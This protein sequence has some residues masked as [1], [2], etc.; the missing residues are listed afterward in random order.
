MIEDFNPNRSP[1]RPLES[2]EDPLA[3]ALNEL[4]AG[5]SIGRAGAS[6][7]RETSPFAGSACPEPGEWSRLA[8]GAAGSAEIDVLLAHAGLCPGCAG[9]LRRSLEM[10]SEDPLPEE[11]AEI[12]NLASGAVEWQHRLAIE[13]ARS[14]HR[15]FP[16]KWLKYKYLWA[17]VGLAACLVIA[18]SVALWRQHGNTPER[19]LAESYTHTRSFDLRMPGA[20]FSAVVPETHLRGGSTGRESAKLL[21]ARAGIERE[22]ERTPD[23][24]HWLQLEARADVM[25]E[26]FD[27]AID[28]LDRLLAAG[29]VTPGL[30]A[31]DASAYF[32]RGTASGSENDRATALD[33]LRRADE[34]APGDPVVLFN[35]AIAMED[36]GL[37]MNA[38]ET[39]NRYLRFERDPRWQAEGRRRLQE[40]ELKLNRIKSHE[41]RMERHLANPQAMRSLADDQA[42]LSAL[43]EELSSTR[44]PTLLRSAF[45]L[46]VDRSRGSPCD[47]GCQAARS[48]LQALGSSL[49]RN[50][51]DPW[52]TQF[53]SP[54][55][56]FQ[57]PQF[58]QAALF[59]GQAIDAD[60]LGDYSGGQRWSARARALFHDLGN[61]AGEDRAEVER[62]YALQRSFTLASCHQAAKALLARDNGFA[63]LRIHAATLDAVCDT[64]P[65]AA[66]ANDT[67]FLRTLQLAQDHHYALLELRA[68]SGLGGIA[69]ESGDVETVWRIALENL[70]RFYGGDYPPLRGA[71][72]VAGPA[73]IEELTPR[74]QLS[75]LVNREAFNLFALSPNRAI[76]AEQRFALIRAAIRAGSLQEA[77]EQMNIARTE[78]AFAPGMKGEQAESE[79]LMAELYLDRNDLTAADRMLN[80][81]HEHMGGED[82][83][84]QLR[85]YAVARGEL[86]LLLGRPDEAEPRLRR[87][88]VEEE[89]QAAGAGAQN[90]V[91]ARQNRELYATLAGIWL[92][93]KRPG[94]E[95]LALWERYRLRIL[96]QPVPVCPDEGLACLGPRLERVLSRF[97][98]HSDGL[99]RADSGEDQLLGQV[100]LLDRVLLYR[101]DAHGVA[102]SEVPFRKE[103]LLGAA[104]ALER[105]TSTPTTSQQSVDQAARRLGNVLLGGL[106]T[107]ST[108]GDRLLLE[109]DPVLGNLP[110]APIETGEGP[111]GLHFNLEEAPSIL[112]EPSE[113]LR[114][115]PAGRPLVVGASIG[116][117]ESQFLPEALNEAGAVARFNKDANLLLAGQATRA[118][119]VPRLATAEAIHFAGHAVRGD[120]G[121]RLLLAS[122]G[123]AGDKPYLDGA[124]F[125]KHPPRTARLVVFSA[126]STGKREEGWNHGMGDIVDTLVSLGVPE[127]VA[128]R[129][130]IDSSSAVP[131][132]D[133]FYGGLSAGLSVP[134]ALTAARLSLI[135][136]VRYRHPY[137][138]A[139]YYASGVGKTDLHEVFHGSNR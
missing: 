112:L 60:T 2:A 136:D 108:A 117:G 40:L 137:Y 128:T 120:G 105:V 8:S 89:L 11:A 84:V 50:H 5:Q 101:A 39:W 80:A 58:L 114:Q 69:A 56:L 27:P 19:L 76:Q 73:F 92:A 20:G 103:D 61:I 63:W 14:S 99:S 32:Q 123:T 34:L 38:V 74:V 91:F 125:R 110:W 98:Q 122:A 64:G 88:I 132:M 100:L 55:S 37:V 4:I 65:G 93:Q 52:L 36:R 12:R 53:L 83:F 29:P 67:L 15:P 26:K 23:D 47:D 6:S 41:S 116:S 45:A 109:A 119:V 121:T 13:L 28:I 104:A 72:T 21:D 46:P 62:I 51:H 135:R 139:A 17:G 16:P 24:S 126:C 113:R 9:S 102:W 31:D 75:L 48:L 49:E 90:V 70:H 130:Q 71:T 7:E 18:A 94:I 81:A 35:E 68:R 30:L 131:M 22:L 97:G 66:S 82:N 124:V 95:I 129:W 85:N 57:N 3:R 87:A 54:D 133:A 25:E 96:G 118:Q 111:I 138:W 127:V 10:F 86:E 33:Y 79:I 44:L 107:S 77:Q 106:R 1:G 134:Q 59:L 43:D 115:E 78:T 42:A